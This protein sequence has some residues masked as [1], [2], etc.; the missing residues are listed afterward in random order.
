VRGRI[1]A[2]LRPVRAVLL[3][4][5][6]LL[7]SAAAGE[8]GGRDAVI[9]RY[10]L[11]APRS[12]EA[13]VPA[14]ARYLARPCRNDAEKA[15][16]IYRWVAENIR[17]DTRA[18]F[19]GKIRSS[20]AA[21]ALRNRTAVCE[22]FSSLFEALGKAA[23]LEVVTVGGWARGF[24]SAAGDPI[25]GRPDHAWNAVRIAGRWRLV[26]P[27]WGGG[28]L[29]EAGRYVRRFDDFFFL[30]PPERL[31]A[32]HFPEDPKWQLLDPPLSRREFE[33]QPFIRPA[34]FRFGLETDSHPDGTIEAD[35]TVTVV[36]RA[37]AA[38]AVLAQLLPCSSES[39]LGAE[40]TFCQ[41]DGES[42]LVRAAFPRKGEYVL[43]VFA[44]NAADPGPAEWAV[45]YRVLAARRSGQTF[46]FP[47]T[48]QG[49]VDHGAFLEAPL[50]GRLAA[51]A[52]H[53]FRIRVPAAEEVMVDFGRSFRILERRGEWF[54]GDVRTPRGEITVYA[55]FAGAKQYTGLLRYS[56]I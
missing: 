9:D 33:N 12:A 2:L 3:L 23:G 41:R 54:E 50:S 46:R 43:R 36:F 11:A 19:S 13:S 56:G 4:A 35:D 5:A 15:R 14:L 55:R 7:P 32:T 45:D 16:A 24:G 39:D 21:G 47:V 31:I 37:P 44:K 28:V 25:R 6:A 26:D 20:G 18:F 17:Y 42:V 52:V 53:A 8:E 10:A 30:V 48:Y 27:T 38:T 34:F 29:D 22:G 1:T 40:H 51:A 49:F